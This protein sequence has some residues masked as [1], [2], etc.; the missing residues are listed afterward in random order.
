MPL[1][2]RLARVNRS[3]TNRITRLIAGRI[4]PLAIVHHV[5]RKSGKLYATPIMVFKRPSGFVIAMTYGTDTEWSKNVLAAGGCTIEYRR[6]LLPVTNP[7][8]TTISDVSGDVPW[9]V[10]FILK[11]INAHDAMMLTRV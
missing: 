7:R 1:P 2:K 5:G 9:L 3:V 4:P 10:R 6:K 11:R 8:L